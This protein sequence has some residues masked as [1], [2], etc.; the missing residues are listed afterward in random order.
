MTEKSTNRRRSVLFIGALALE[1]LPEAMKSG[2][3]IVCVDLEDA[4][5]PGRKAEGRTALERTLQQGSAE[6]E[7]QLAARINSVRSLD[8]V[9]DLLTCL[10]LQPPRLGAL[11]LPK[12]ESDDE[13]RWAGT[14]ADEAKSR[15]EL[16]AIVETNDGLENCREIAKSHP[17]LKALFF[18]GF[19]LSTALG[20]AMAWEPLL[21][22]RSRVVHAAASAGIEALDSPFPE[23]NNLQGLRD[24]AERAQSLGMVGKAVKHASQIAAITD[25]FTP[26]SRDIERARKIL[27]L[28]AADPTKPLVFEGKLIE[29]PTIKRLRRVAEFGSTPKVF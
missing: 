8:G 1:G 9:T 2:A 25:I 19:D 20:S 28:F 14:L 12:V 15:L 13:V 23:V 22:A 18:G 6:G 5:P 4:V 16:Y 27:E 3:D 7:V 29:L 26:Q 11:V 17:R 21:Y 24:A 10:Q